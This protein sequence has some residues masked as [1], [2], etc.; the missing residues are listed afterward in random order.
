M[1]ITSRDNPTQQLTFQFDDAEWATLAWINTNRSEAWFLLWLEG[2]WKAMDARKNEQLYSDRAAAFRRATPEI[3][4][5][6]DLL[7]GVT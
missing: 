4:A 7:L 5:E 2:C 6:I 3:K 1:I